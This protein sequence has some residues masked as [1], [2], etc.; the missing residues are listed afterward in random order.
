MSDV[1]STPNYSVRYFNT[2]AKLEKN[3][4]P[5]QDS[6]LDVI[7]DNNYHPSA[8]ST[9]N[10]VKDFIA[11]K[12]FLLVQKSDKKITSHPELR[13][14]FAGTQPTGK[15]HFTHSEEVFLDPSKKV[16]CAISTSRDGSKMDNNT[17]RI[18]DRKTKS[19]ISYN[20]SIYTDNKS[21]CYVDL[22]AKLN[23]ANYFSLGTD[24]NMYVRNHK[25][26]AKDMRKIASI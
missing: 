20:E 6:V 15:F 10:A 25:N 26:W 13:K 3:T 5:F 1:I 7:N 16:I 21:L 19:L 8:N 4:T 22:S 23:N 14:P 2:E 17:I 11:E 12:G 9:V 24:T 18:Y